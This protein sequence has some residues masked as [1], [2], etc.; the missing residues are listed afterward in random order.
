MTKCCRVAERASRIAEHEIWVRAAVQE[1][2]YDPRSVA[3][4]GQCQGG[5]APLSV[6]SDL[7]SVVEQDLRTSLVSVPRGNE[8]GRDFLVPPA[9]RVRPRVDARAVIQQP[10]G[11]VRLVL[12]YG[13][14]QSGASIGAPRVDVVR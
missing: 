2:L 5:I 1:Q 12:V 14:G 9:I 3:L 11:R 10:R 8:E 4:R 6:C 13:D 7:R